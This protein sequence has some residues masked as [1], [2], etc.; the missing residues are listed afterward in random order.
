MAHSKMKIEPKDFRVSSGQKVRLKKWATDIK[1]LYKSDKHYK[2]CLNADVEELSALQRL[3]YASNNYS[4]LLIFQAMD[5]AGKDGAISHVL[6]GVNPQGCEVYSFKHPSSEELLHDFLWRTTRC[7]PARGRI[8]VFNRSYYEE[9]LIARVHPEI[10]R[11]EKIPDGQADPKTVWEGRYRSI[12]DLEKHL[13]RNGTVVLK[14]FLHLS[15]EE[16]RKRFLERIDEPDKNWKF[17]EADI[18]ERKFWDQYMEAYEDCL[19]AT[20]TKAAPWHVVPAD[21]KLNARLIISRIVIDALKELKMSYP[22]VT[23]AR[24]SEL[25]KIRE[26]LTK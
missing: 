22:E 24:K 23:A 11:S 25:H 18:V 6:S 13:H 9:V 26:Q 1:S 3:L 14:F 10:L 20:S 12:V 4:V 2:E 19:S 5:A 8:G 16:Q 15:K 7:L 21:D 17:S